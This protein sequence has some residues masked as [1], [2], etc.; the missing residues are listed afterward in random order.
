M[1]PVR[2][3]G[4]VGFQPVPSDHCAWPSLNSVGPGGESVP[5]LLLSGA[6]SIFLGDA[7]K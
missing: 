3:A 4:N 1:V 6:D 7:S 2:A 5:R